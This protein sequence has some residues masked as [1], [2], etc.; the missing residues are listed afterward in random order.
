MSS[1]H[2]RATVGGRQPEHNGEDCSFHLVGVGL[3]FG[4]L[5]DGRSS[6]VAMVMTWGCAFEFVEMFDTFGVVLPNQAL[7]PLAAAVANGNTS[8]I[9]LGKPWKR[10]SK[11]PDFAL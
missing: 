3:L 10:V 8:L 7:D 4:F 2:T 9:L 5:C 1:Q 6:T 11:T